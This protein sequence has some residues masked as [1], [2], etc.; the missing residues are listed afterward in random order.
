M[1]H[2][3]VVVYPPQ[4][5]ARR[6][7][8]RGEPVGTAYGLVDLEEFLRLAGLDPDDVALDD[9]ALIEWRGGGPEVWE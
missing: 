9:P 4:D 8:V 3:P 2:P 7:T 5:G 1:E 6:V